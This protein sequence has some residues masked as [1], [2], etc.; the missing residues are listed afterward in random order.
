MPSQPP[1]PPLLAPYLSHSTHSPQSLTLITSV[2]AAT[3]NW[4][5]L[6]YLHSVLSQTTTSAYGQIDNNDTRNEDRAAKRIV[7]VSFL[8]DW[9]FWKAEGKRL[10]CC[11]VLLHFSSCCVGLAAD[12]VNSLQGLDLQ[13]FV[14]ADRLKFVDGLTGLFE[15]KPQQQRQQQNLRTTGILPR[16]GTGPGSG[17][18]IPM[19]GG[20]AESIPVRTPSPANITPSTAATSTNPKQLHI[21][22]ASGGTSVLNALENDILSVIK[23]IIAKN[24]NTAN[25]HNNEEGEQDEDVLLIIDQPDFVLA[26]TPGIDADDMSEWI[27]GLQQVCSY[28]LVSRGISTNA[29]Y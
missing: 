9:A 19:R 23:A 17:R 26:A 16:P 25:N 5:I 14:D 1:I 27:M 20:P 7:L 10:V 15:V 13:R 8:R 11:Y 22:S 6:R 18:P 12:V 24:P 3:S 28:V 4:L 21:S 2:L 29:H